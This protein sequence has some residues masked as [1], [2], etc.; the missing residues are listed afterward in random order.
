M[1]V[2]DVEKLLSPLSPDAPCGEDLAYD[3]AYMELDRLAQGTPERQ[4]G[5]SII[6]AEEPNWRQVAEAANELLTRTKSLRVIVHA[7]LAA[8]K[9]EGLPALRDGLAVLRGV[10][11]RYWD[12]VYPQLDP[13][14]P[15]PIERVNIIAS[16]LDPQTFIRAVRETPLCH[17]V[18]LGQFS[19]RHIMLAHGE[20]GVLPEKGAPAVDGGQI[21]A[22]FKDTPS[23]ELQATAQAA[24]EAVGH[25][26]GLDDFLTQTIGA[27]QARDLTPFRAILERVGKELQNALAQR[28][29]A[30][31]VAGAE[32]AGAPAAEAG[33][34]GVAAQ[35][36]QPLTGE[37]RSPQDVLAAFDK[38]CRY[39]EAHEPSSPV[40]L[41]V[42]GAQRLVS[43]NF[44]EI[45]QVLTP[46]AIRQIESICGLDSG[47]APA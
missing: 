26:Q 37:I 2:L 45:I 31:P 5:E 40:P 36:V 6:P 30:A 16:L 12:T 19:L 34:P 24:A 3:T 18:Q 20:P 9:L 41:L 10:V 44:T 17:S 47:S 33:A 15:D 43:K 21:E 4:V 22:A 35:A 42:R 25:V 8:L 28:G 11:E 1:A 14:D 23:D 27:G 13:E 39:Y 46:E 7:A 32:A 29:L 38:I